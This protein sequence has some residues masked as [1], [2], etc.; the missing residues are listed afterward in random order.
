MGRS[1][2]ADSIDDS[3]VFLKRPGLLKSADEDWFVPGVVDQLLGCFMRA[4]LGRI[5]VA[6]SHPL[7]ID[8]VVQRCEVEVEGHGDRATND[9]L[10]LVRK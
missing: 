9:G 6:R 5:K 1:P 3:D 10:H 2:R 8:L 4:R 7:L